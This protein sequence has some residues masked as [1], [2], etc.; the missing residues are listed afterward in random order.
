M[1]KFPKAQFMKEAVEVVEFEAG[2]GK[3]RITEKRCQ[4]LVNVPKPRTAGGLASYLGALGFV[5]NM[6][7]PGY[8]E[9]AGVLRGLIKDADPT[10]KLPDGLKS[11]PS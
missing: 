4:G 5:R 7:P 9:V 3:V 11:Q 6:L 8:S 2:H 1:S 10:L